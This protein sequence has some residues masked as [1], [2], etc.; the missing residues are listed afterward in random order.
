MPV[1]ISDDPQSDDPLDRY[2]FAEPVVSVVQSC[3]TPFTV[4]VLEIGVPTRP[5]IL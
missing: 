3:D 1:L 5:R 4:G 2:R